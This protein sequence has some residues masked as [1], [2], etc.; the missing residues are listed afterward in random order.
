[1]ARLG[2]GAPIPSGG[3]VTKL[4]Y[5]EH[6]R[7]TADTALGLLGTAAT[8]LRRARGRTVAGPLPVRAG[9][10]PRRRHRRDPAHHHRRARA[11]AAARARRTEGEGS[12][13]TCRPGSGPP[14]APLQEFQ[15]RGQSRPAHAQGRADPGPTRR[16]GQDV[17]ERDGFLGARIVDI[18]E[19]ASVAT[20]SFYH[21]FDSKEQI[22]REVAQLQEQRLTAPRGGRRDRE[23]TPADQPGSASAWPTVITWSATENEAA[24]M[25]VIEQVSRYDSEVN[26]ARMATMKHFVERAARSIRQLQADGPGRHQAQRLHGGRRPGCHGR[27]LRRA[28]ARAGLSLLRLRRR[29]RAA[30][31]ALGERPRPRTR[32]GR[33]GRTRDDNR[34]DPA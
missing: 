12:W 22:F 27:P 11:R 33:V 16:R 4:L 3:P 8:V 26:E 30:D 2:A 17:F 14:G 9:P 24:L 20:G 34:A 18:A 13:L 5:S 28:V 7:R 19:T 23:A 32:E 29:R 10:S 6:A 15:G 31:P 21:Y 1:M 25:G